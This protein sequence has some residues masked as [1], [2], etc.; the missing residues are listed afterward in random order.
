[1]ISYDEEGSDASDADA[2]EAAPGGHRAGQPEDEGE[3]AEQDEEDLAARTRAQLQKL[4]QGHSPNQM[5]LSFLRKRS[6]QKTAVVIAFV[7]QPIEDEY[8]RDLQ[9]MKGDAAQQGQWCAR[10]AQGTGHWWQT[11]QE[12]MDVVQGP[13]LANRLRFRQMTVAVGLDAGHDWLEE[14]MTLGQQAW[15]LA[16]ECVAGHVLAQLP[17]R[18]CLPEA[19]AIFLLR[20]ARERKTEVARLKAVVLA[21]YAAEAYIRTARSDDATA[22]GLTQL[23]DHLGW[24]HQQTAR[25]MMALMLQCSFDADNP[26]CTQLAGK[27]YR[28]PS[29]TKNCLEDAFAHLHRLVSLSVTNKKMADWTKWFYATTTP[30]L[31]ETLILPDETFWREEVGGG[32]YKAIA[33][34]MSSIFSTTLTEMPEPESPDSVLLP[35]P[36]QMVQKWRAAGPEANQRSAAATAFLLHDQESSWRHVGQ[37]WAG[38]L[39]VPRAVYKHKRRGTYHLALGFRSY[40]VPAIRCQTMLSVNGVARTLL[41]RFLKVDGSHQDGPDWLFNFKI[42][43]EDTEY[44]HVPTR[45]LCPAA[46]PPDLRIG[47]FALKVTGELQSLLKSALRSGIFLTVPQLTEIAAALELPALPAGASKKIHRAKQLVEHVFGQTETRQSKKAMVAKLMKMSVKKMTEDEETVLQ[48]VGQL[49]SENAECFKDIK[50]YAQ[51]KLKEEMKKAG[52]QEL[53]KKARAHHKLAGGRA[54]RKLKLNFLKNRQQ[55]LKKDQQ[56]MQQKTASSAR[57]AE[58]PAAASSAGPSS[59][60]PRAGAVHPEQRVGVTPPEFKDLLPGRGVLTRKFVPFRNNQPNNMFYKITYTCVG[61]PGP[62]SCQRKWPS[63]QNPDEISALTT[64]LDWVYPGWNRI[65]PT[66]TFEMQLR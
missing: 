16:T 50:A 39:F 15:D 10:R 13:G 22:A 36:G 56:A 19:F 60:G 6:L 45:P 62:Q 40:G 20:D 63:M 51:Q 42:A 23:F 5:V 48:M 1:G 34:E 27:L 38:C 12:I 9:A 49:D 35:Q 37:V 28:G 43:D 14:E 11:A 7:T 3:A 47:G 26:Q 59:P 52:K 64:V 61:E 31:T 41:D 58:A 44:E 29:S 21:V 17:H 30:Y 66:N 8:N 32:A 33:R 2:D 55:K 65:N 57:P 18:Y 4:W 24:A 53:L 54:Q 46:L 25:E